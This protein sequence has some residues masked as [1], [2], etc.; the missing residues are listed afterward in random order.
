MTCDDPVQFGQRLDLVD[1][2]LAHL[3]GALG[4][5]LRHFQHA[6]AKFV[7]RG[8]QLVVHFGRHL[9]H[10][11]H[12]GGE[13]VRRLLEHRIG[14]L[15]ALL[16]DLA[17]G[18]GGQPALLFGRGA[19][20]L[21]LPADGG[22]TRTGGFRHHPGDVARALFGSRQQFIEQTGESR[23]PLVEIGGAQIDGGDQRFQ[24][25]FAFG[26]GSGG[27]AVALLDHRSGSDERLAVSLELAGKRAEIFQRLGGFGVEHRQLVF[28]RLGRKAVARADVVDGGHEVG[29]AG[30][31]RAFQRIEIIVRAGKHFLQQDI[32]LAQPLEQRDRVGAQNLAGFLHLGHCRDRD[33]TRLV[34]RRRGRPARGPSATCSPRRW[35]VR[36]PT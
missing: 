36:R 13:L 10:A 1:D 28:Q 9:L 23:Q 21:E 14:F 25:R 5:L 19:N 33:L 3:R 32:A 26:D 7:A 29:H 16:I 2:H 17:H 12:H 15:R 11:R 8:V 6:A 18:I 24:H 4:G 20:R 22:R 27:G 35:R 34:D 30:D 31:Q